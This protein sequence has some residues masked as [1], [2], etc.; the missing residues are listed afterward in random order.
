MIYRGSQ[1]GP[2]PFKRKKGSKMT[3]YSID[4]RIRGSEHTRNVLVDAKNLKSAKKKIG[5]KHGY[6]SGRMIVITSVVVC[7][8]F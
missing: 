7:G 4:Y 8:Y 5:K 2:R 3:S 1:K 6:K